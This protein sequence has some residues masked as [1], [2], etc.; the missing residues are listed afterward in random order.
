MQCT[1]YHSYAMV[2]VRP[3]SKSADRLMGPF[4]VVSTERNNVTV[5]DLTAD[6]Y[7]TYDISRLRHFIVAPGIDPR[8][9]AAAD[10]AEEV[11]R[12][13]LKHKGNPKQRKTLQFEVEWEPDGDITWESWETMRK[14]DILDDYLVKHKPL[15]YLMTPINNG[16]SNKKL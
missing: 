14:L 11:V 12:K 5:K 10:L 9:I 8:D 15:R 13:I 7:H 2:T 16:K 1:I 4:Q 3:P 6:N